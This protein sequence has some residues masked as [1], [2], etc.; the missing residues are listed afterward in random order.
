MVRAWI[1][2]Q[3]EAGMAAGVARQ[4]AEIPGVTRADQVL[5]YYD[6]IACADAANAAELTELVTGSIQAVPGITRTLTCWR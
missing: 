1:I 4:V 2:M 5:G 3:T 6:V